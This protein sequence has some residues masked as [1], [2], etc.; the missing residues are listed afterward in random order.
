MMSFSKRLA[1][2][3]AAGLSLQAIVA[4]TSRSGIHISLAD[5]RW[6]IN[7]EVTYQGAPVEGLLL[8][9]RMVNS[10]FED[11][12]KPEFNIDGNTDKFVASIPEYVAA[13]VR[14]FTLNFQGGMPGYEGAV[15]SAFNPDGSLRQSYL[16]RIE[17]VVKACDRAG[18]AVILGCF[19]QRQD[20]ILE[21]E[22]A[23]RAAVVNAAKWIRERN[24]TNVLLEIANEHRHRGFDHEII[25]TPEGMAELI[26]L[27][28][29]ENADLLVSASGLGNGRIDSLVAEASD[30]ILIHF[31]S[32]PVEEIQLRVDALKRYN[33][34]IVCNEDNKVD[35]EAVRAFTAAVQAGC[36]WGYMNNSVNQYVP[37]EFNGVEDDP[38]LYGAMKGLTSSQP[39]NSRTQL[40]KDNSILKND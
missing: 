38:V 1:C 21:D 9:V 24:L 14:A 34:A 26:R 2:Y 39:V 27:A 10:T 28:R 5:G 18:A 30:Y 6:F 20:Q 32:T 8:N 12:T 37:F 40:E 31:N 13:G 17:R 19:Y 29:T 11:A 22:A 23:V 3:L 4:C 16:D 15:N 36:S 35:A 7:G 33:K 25:R